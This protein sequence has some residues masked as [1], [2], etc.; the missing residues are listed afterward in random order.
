MYAENRY[1]TRRESFLKTTR[2]RDTKRRLAFHFTRKFESQTKFHDGCRTSSSQR[3]DDGNRQR[4]MVAV[5]HRRASYPH[6][7]PPASA[8]FLTGFP[9]LY[10]PFLVFVPNRG[11]DVGFPC[12]EESSLRSTFRLHVIRGSSIM[13]QGIDLREK[14]SPACS[15]PATAHHSCLVID[16]RSSGTSR[17]S[18]DG[19]HPAFSSTSLPV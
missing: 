1:V 9:R 3:S 10:I 4:R 18:V 6:D 16:Y 2:G 17:I 7:P 5:R 11:D 13:S 15:S 8:R 19:K 14:R 12:R